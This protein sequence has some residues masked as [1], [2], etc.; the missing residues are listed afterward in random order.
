MDQQHKVEEAVGVALC[1]CGAPALFWVIYCFEEL[2][3]WGAR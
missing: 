1:I 3:A 2:V